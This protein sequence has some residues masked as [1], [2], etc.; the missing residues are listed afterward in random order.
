M[1]ALLVSSDLNQDLLV[2]SVLMT[3][4]FSAHFLSHHF[5]FTLLRLYPTNC[6]G[7]LH[8]FTFWNVRLQLLADFI[9]NFL[10]APINQ[11][12]SNSESE[13]CCR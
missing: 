5:L 12:A 7:F 10:W 6:R 4:D 11:Y 9:Q 3:L 2:A 8:V 13:V 1:Q